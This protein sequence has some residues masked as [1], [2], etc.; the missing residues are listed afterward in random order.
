MEPYSEPCFLGNQALLGVSQSLMGFRGQSGWD[1]RSAFG[2]GEAAVHGQYLLLA[3]LLSS[4]TQ[5]P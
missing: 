4:F 3:K 1:E 2:W 5:Y